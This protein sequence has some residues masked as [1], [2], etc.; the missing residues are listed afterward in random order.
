[1]NTIHA[2]FHMTIKQDINRVTYSTEKHKICITYIN[3]MFT[4]RITIIV[5]ITCTVCFLQ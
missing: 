4:F 5:Y 1:M 2:M 3:T